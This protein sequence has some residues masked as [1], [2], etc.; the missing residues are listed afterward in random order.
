M[1]SI[2]NR[3]RAVPGSYSYTV[4]ESVAA[5]DSN[6]YNLVPGV[7][8]G[9]ANE[10]YNSDEAAGGNGSDPGIVLCDNFYHGFHYKLNADDANLVRV[11]QGYN[12]WVAATKGWNGTIFTPITNNGVDSNFKGIGGKKYCATSGFRNGD[13]GM[14][15][16]HRFSNGN[17]GFTNTNYTELWA[18]WYYRVDTG[19]TWG[20]EKHTN[21]TKVSGDITWFNVQFNCGTGSGGHTSANPAIQIIHGSDLCQNPNISAVNIVPNIWYCM[22]VHMKLNSSGTVADGAI[23]YYVTNCGA[24]G[25]SPVNDSG[26]TTSSPILRTQMTNVV[27]Q[28]NQSGC[29]DTPC[30][31]ETA[32]FENYANPPSVGTSY[33]D[34][35]VIRK[36]RA[37]G[38]YGTM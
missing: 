13:Q 32:W 10:F 21:F 11:T 28:R 1:G 37:P 29:I 7:V 17:G 5:V 19:Y 24:N 15:A 31:I 2:R 9:P 33:L 34:G 3:V 14:M 36:D 6:S 8:G 22:H 4:N 16:D 30:K 38:F 20:G 35:I 12:A 23:E 26:V 27:F 18:R 25:L